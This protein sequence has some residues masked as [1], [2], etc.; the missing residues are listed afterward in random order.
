[1]KRYFYANVHVGSGGDIY[2][3]CLVSAVWCVCAAVVIRIQVQV[4]SALTC[5]STECYFSG[6]DLMQAKY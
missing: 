3:D 6:D 2:D 5:D 4:L 1:M